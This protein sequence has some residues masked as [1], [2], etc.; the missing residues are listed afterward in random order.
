MLAL[1][2]T[3]PALVYVLLLLETLREMG[4][5]PRVCFGC[6][7][8]RGSVEVETGRGVGG[9]DIVRVRVGMYGCGIVGR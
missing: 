3:P 7:W 2:R 5:G 4:Q 1:E 9:E 6:G 8:R